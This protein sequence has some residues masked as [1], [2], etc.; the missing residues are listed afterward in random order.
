MTPEQRNETIAELFN[1][2]IRLD[3]KGQEDLLESSNVPDDVRRE[4]EMLLQAER[5][6][7][8]ERRRDP[9]QT[10]AIAGAEADGPETDEFSISS[11]NPAGATLTDNLETPSAGTPDSMESAGRPSSIGKFRLLQLLGVGGYGQVWKAYDTVLDRFVALKIPRDDVSYRFNRKMVEREARAAAQFQHP[12][13]VTIHEV[14]F[15]GDRALIASELIEGVTLSKS[16][17]ASSL[18]IKQTA[19]ICAKLADAIHYAHCRGVIHRDLKPSNILVDHAGE[20]HV[21]DFGLAKRELAHTTLSAEGSVLGTPTYMPPEQARGDSHS[22]DSRSDI[23]SLGVILFQMLTSE[24]PF[25]GDRQAVIQKVIYVDPPSPRSLKPDIPRDLETICLKCLQKSPARRYQSAKELATDLELWLDRKPIHARPVTRLERGLRLCARYPLV[26]S[27]AMAIVLLVSVSLVVITSLYFHADRNEKAALR[28]LKRRTAN[29]EKTIQAVEVM[30]SR[31]IEREEPE[32]VG[33][34]RELL[35]EALNL[36]EQLV[37]TNGDDAD[38]LIENARIKTRMGYLYDALEQP[39]D[40]LHAFRSS[41]D[42]FETALAGTKQADT[43]EELAECFRSE[44]RMLLEMSTQG[45]SDW[46]AFET[47]IR[48]AIE[49]DAAA[50][51]IEPERRFSLVKSHNLCARM[52]VSR[53]DYERAEQEY[54]RTI[55]LLEDLKADTSAS[56]VVKLSLIWNRHQLADMYV[57]QDKLEQA[58]QIHE[59]LLQQRLQLQQVRPDGYRFHPSTVVNYPSPKQTFSIRRDLAA[60]HRTLGQICEAENDDEAAAVHFRA[61]TKLMDDVVRDYPHRQSHWNARGGLHTRYSQI[62]MRL[63]KR[64]EALYHCEIGLQSWSQAAADPPSDG[65]LKVFASHHE[66]AGSLAQQIKN[67]E[68][69]IL[70]FVAALQFYNQLGELAP[71]DPTVDLASIRISLELAALR[72]QSG[73]EGAASELV[74]HAVELTESLKQIDQPNKAQLR[75]IRTAERLL[76]KHAPDQIAP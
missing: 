69:A 12:N 54:F 42:Q 61:A 55:K 19:E 74:R 14:I 18:A 8:S 76:Q 10:Q 21:T 49:I 39:A 43:S 34:Q 13:I 51:P 15:Y 26:S 7:E 50:A 44:A 20:P 53:G 52:C 75:A 70:H 68:A 1:E 17:A 36:Y 67:H 27:L 65:R 22:A 24:L 33:I 5:Q 59:D 23:Y 72:R 9:D 25:R 56:G 6:M 66:T 3:R 63:G 45:Q 29:F 37:D 47:A 40:A 58:R 64:E 35:N 11:Q 16:I 38:S 60:T 46:D 62:L 48:R 31:V 32:F 28:H 41:A 4:I 57:R 2:A 73:D 30:L 71:E